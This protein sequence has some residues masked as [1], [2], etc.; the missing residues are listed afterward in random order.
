M[1]PGAS[2]DLVLLGVCQSGPVSLHELKK[3]C[4]FLRA[5]RADCKF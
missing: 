2:D 5:S 4:N 1:M 3:L